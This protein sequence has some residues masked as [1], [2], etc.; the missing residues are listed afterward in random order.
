MRHAISALAVGL[1]LAA[2]S[3]PDLSGTN[4]SCTADIDCLGGKVCKLSAGVDGGAP[5]GVCVGM[6]DLPPITVG[7][8]APFQGPSQD[9]GLEMKRGIQLAFDA[10]NAA[11]GIR[12]RKLELEFKDDQYTPDLADQ[13]A[14]ALV[15]VQVGS[16]PPHCPTSTTPGPAVL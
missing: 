15:D 10:Q 1:A 6:N 9:L 11:G 4:F 13:N 8:S 5:T 7:M 3:K 2:C 16:A 12:G 14:R